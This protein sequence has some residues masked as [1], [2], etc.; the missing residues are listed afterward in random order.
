MHIRTFGELVDWVRRIHHQLSEEMAASSLKQ[1]QERAK[2]LL[3]YLAEHEAKLDL[4]IGEFERQGDPKA[5][6]TR[7]YDY[8]DRNPVQ[9]HRLCDKLY[10][11]MSFDDISRE[12]FDVHDQIMSLYQTLIGKAEIPE[13]RQ[14]MESLLELE[15]HEAM[16]LARQIGRMDDV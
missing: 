9:T 4:A 10:A 2:M 7:L 15:E 13:I 8:F 3:Q 14:L 6:S 12:V 1:Q 16:L 11:D 5:M